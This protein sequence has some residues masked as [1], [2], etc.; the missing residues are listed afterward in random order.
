MAL[1]AISDLHLP[2][3]VNKPMDVFGKNWENY[4]D[5]L[6]QNWQSTVQ[7][8][9]IVVIPGD[10]SWATYLEESRADFDFLSRLNGHKILLKGN[11]DYWWGTMNKLREFVT[12]NGY[13]NIDFL[14]NNSFSYKDIS[15]CGTRLWNTPQGTH[16]GDDKK[17]Y[18]REL[19][20]FEL[21]VADAKYSDNIIAFTHFP[22]ILKDYTQNAMVNLLN[23]YGI[24]KCVFGHIHSSGVKNVREG[25]VDGIDYTL[26]SCD[27]REFMPLKIAD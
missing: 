15:I 8:D 23:K 27:Y 22:P 17:I 18:E 24:K 7:T 9:D 2:L 26:V 1:Y 14:Q 21:S 19:I 16:T 4:V 20:R 5:R 10:F 13:K 25:I 12:E 6:F 11:H 3:G